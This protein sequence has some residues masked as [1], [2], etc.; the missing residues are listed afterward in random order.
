MTS[1]LENHPAKIVE[2]QRRTGGRGGG[3]IRISAKTGMP[4][5]VGGVGGTIPEEHE[6]EEE[7]GTGDGSDGE[8]SG[9]DGAPEGEAWDAGGGKHGRLGG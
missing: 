6:E 4:L 9:S 7:Q 3:A 5:S 2:P 1:N 8:G